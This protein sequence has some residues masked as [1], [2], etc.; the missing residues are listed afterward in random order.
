MSVRDFFTLHASCFTVFVAGNGR[1][2]PWGD[3]D[4]V[5]HWMEHKHSTILVS[6]NGIIGVQPGNKSLL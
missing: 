5:E 6:I 2:Q 4:P 1:R 3:E